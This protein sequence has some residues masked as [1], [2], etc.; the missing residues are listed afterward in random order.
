VGWGCEGRRRILSKEERWYKVVKP[1][2]YFSVYGEGSG[3]ACV[4]LNKVSPS[5][6]IR[7]VDVFR[8]RSVS[9]LAV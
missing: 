4:S 1:P 3:D 8:H 9:K 2:R 6:Y 7:G 5:L